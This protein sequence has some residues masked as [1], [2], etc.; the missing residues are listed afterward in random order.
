MSVFILQMPYFDRIDVSEEIDEGID[1]Q[2]NQKSAM[3]LTTGVF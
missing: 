1:W 2:L 3:F